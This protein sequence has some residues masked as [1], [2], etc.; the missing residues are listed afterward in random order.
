M[1]IRIKRIFILPLIFLLIFSSVDFVYADG[2]ISIKNWKID[3]QILENGDLKI[4]EDI[5]FYFNSDFNGVFRDINLNET[6]GIEDLKIERL[7]KD[8]TLY[9]LV[10][11]AKD[12][13]S[14]VYTVDKEGDNLNIKIYS[15]SE[16]EDKTF[17][18]SYTLKTTARKYRDVSE[19]YHKFI[20]ENNSTYIENLDINILLPQNKTDEVRIFAHGH[21]DLD[22]GFEGE[23]RVKLHMDY[24]ED[25]NMIEARILMPADFLPDLATKT[26]EDML[27]IILEQEE[28]YLKEQARSRTIKAK[29]EK[30]VNLLTIIALISGAILAIFSYFRNKHNIAPY[31]EQLKGNLIY[32]P[33]AIITNLTRAPFDANMI[34]TTLYHLSHKGFISI[35][36]DG[37]FKKKGSKKEVENF[38]IT[39]LNKDRSDLLKHEVFLL[40][41]F[42][43]DIAMGNSLTSEYLYQYTRKNSSKFNQKFT[44]WCKEVSKDLETLELKDNS[45]VKLGIFITSFA[46]VLWNFK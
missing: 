36:D 6:D 14:E 21:K 25:Y 30:G 35:E 42:F 20:G 12:G 27:D 26:D 3:G 5:N 46:L 44:D 23:D 8:S 1:D 40:D 24:L 37:F 28:S 33:P 7:G 38:K 29:R 22:I 9:K 34:I 32:L 19:L 18:F 39:N 11:S 31:Q 43:K 15:P 16:Y 2:D 10:D 13:D 4:V 41:W 45:Q 17:R